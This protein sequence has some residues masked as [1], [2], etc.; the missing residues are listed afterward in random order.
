MKNF[1]QN[2]DFLKNFNSQAKA[3]LISYYHEK[4]QQDTCFESVDNK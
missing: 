3:C 1:I 2:N 4:N